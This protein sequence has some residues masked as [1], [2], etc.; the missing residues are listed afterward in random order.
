MVQVFSRVLYGQSHVVQALPLPSSMGGHP[1]VILSDLE[2]RKILSK[3][4][5]NRKTFFEQF[6][7]GKDDG[8]GKNVEGCGG[9]VLEVRIGICIIDGHNNNSA[10]STNY[11]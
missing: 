8:N 2:E 10:C 4:G 1:A 11:L 9:Y 7:E 6:A 3:D 5:Q